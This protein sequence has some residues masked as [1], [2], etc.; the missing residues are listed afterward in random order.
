MKRIVLFTVA[1][2]LIAFSGVQAQSGSG[3]GSAAVSVQEE[4]EQAAAHD[5]SIEKRVDRE[6][7]RVYY[8]RKNASGPTG[9]SDYCTVEY[10]SRSGKFVNVSPKGQ[11][12]TKPQAPCIRSASLAGQSSNHRPAATHSL[13]QKAACA[14]ACAGKNA[15]AGKPGNRHN[16][17]ARLAKQRQ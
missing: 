7:G 4:A 6:T 9:E 16:P 2:G 15:A 17:K 10:C 13:A 8:V 11:S 5:A 14:G 12:C 1:I 3:A